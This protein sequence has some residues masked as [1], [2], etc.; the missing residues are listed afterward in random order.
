MPYSKPYEKYLW[1]D[2]WGLKIDVPLHDE[3]PALP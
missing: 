2:E 3:Y 1:V